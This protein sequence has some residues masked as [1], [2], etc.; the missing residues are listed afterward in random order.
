MSVSE[1]QRHQLFQWFEE[2]MGPERV[3]VMMDLLPPVGWGDL[4]T[5]TDLHALRAELKGDIK[6]LEGEIG[7]LGGKMEH[8]FGRL[9]KSIYLSMLA[10][11]A[12]VVGLVLAVLQAA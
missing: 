9:Q 4:A 6:V 7:L 8:A 12:T 11:N 5:K 1:S 10:S 3:A 2:A